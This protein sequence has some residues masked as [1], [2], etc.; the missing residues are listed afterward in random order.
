MEEIRAGA[1]VMP[2]AVE[3]AD[4]MLADPRFT[5]KLAHIAATRRTPPIIRC[6]HCGLMKREHDFLTNTAKRNLRDSWCRECSRT[7]HDRCQ[8]NHQDEFWNWLGA[9]L[10]QRPGFNF[11][12]RGT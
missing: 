4:A 10:A 8:V 1:Y 11:I 3:V 2:S 6:V 12:S 5:G 7:E 9:E